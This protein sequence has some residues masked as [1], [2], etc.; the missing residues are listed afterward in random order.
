MRINKDL[1]KTFTL[2]ESLLASVLFIGV[3]IALAG[4]SKSGA[5]QKGDTVTEL[6]YQAAAGMVTLPEL[7]EDLGYLAPLK[8]NYVGSVQGGPQDI[9]A[10]ITGAVDFAGAFNG[11]FVKAAA[12]KVNI[13]SVIGSYGS[14]EKS[15][16]GYFVLADSPI[17]NVHDLI[18]KKVGVNTL[19]AH[20]E[21]AL[22][23]YLARG[24]LT[25]AEI[26][27]VEL[28]VLPPVNTE[29]ALR[30]KQIDVAVLPFILRDK[31]IE[32][33]GIR[34]LFADTE[35][36]GNFTAGTLAVTQKFAKEHP[37]AVSQFVSGTA[38]AIEWARST[39]D[40][41]VKARLISIINKRQRNESTALVQY[42][43]S[44][45]VAE[46]GGLVTPK[47][48]QPWID[49]MVKAGELKDGQVKADQ[50]FS[51]EF[52]SFAKAKTAATT[53][54]AGEQK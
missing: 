5:P 24:G 2:V 11:A 53:A 31:A 13:V 20:F 46:K 16:A 15:W 40:D 25:P 35:L 27:K 43:H 50:L 44:F 9:Q 28:V 48:F 41:Q 29:Q 6:R 42:W 54:K 22:K 7:A 12:A 1:Y 17:K 30:A 23:D 52:N 10:L 3:V 32:R 36:Y 38:K 45:G 14:D 47:Q 4:C 51:N 33:G 39:P 49:L 19:G 8:L 34:Q 21:F 18:G 37:E 26:Q